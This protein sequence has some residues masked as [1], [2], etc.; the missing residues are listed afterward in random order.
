MG[1][2]ARRRASADGRGVCT[3]RQ[4]GEGGAALGG[5]FARRAPTCGRTSSASRPVGAR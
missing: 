4:R 2:R 5:S 1:L 3:D